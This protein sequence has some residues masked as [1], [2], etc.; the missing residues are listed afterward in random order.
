M[1]ITTRD[2]DNSILAAFKAIVG[3]DTT[4]FSYAME[5]RIPHDMLLGSLDY[6]ESQYVEEVRDVVLSDC[7][8]CMDSFDDTDVGDLARYT[9][10]TVADALRALTG[11]DK[12]SLVDIA[13]AGNKRYSSNGF[14]IFTCPRTNSTWTSLGVWADDCYEALEELESWLAEVAKDN[15]FDDEEA[16]HEKELW[17]SSPAYALES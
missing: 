1:A 12:I 17:M 5:G 13:G 7:N 11:W 2:I 9:M 14:Y 4:D 6:W 8:V 15:C 10:S 16:A 3:A